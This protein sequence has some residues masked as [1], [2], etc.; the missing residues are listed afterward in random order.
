[1]AIKQ[2]RREV[3]S[4]KN[5]WWWVES[6]PR[7]LSWDATAKCFC[8]FTD[9]LL[10]KCS[11]RHFLIREL[12]F[13]LL[14]PSSLFLTHKIE[15]WIANLADNFNFD[16]DPSVSIDCE[17]S[18]LT[19]RTDRMIRWRDPKISE[20]SQ[21][22][23]FYYLKLRRRRRFWRISWETIDDREPREMAKVKICRMHFCQMQ[24]LKKIVDS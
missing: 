1:M 6:N 5:N 9:Q 14:Q 19:D 23:S 8:G 13:L 18:R 17:R 11:W 16:A 10:F 7:P 22:L 15:H 4:P 12:R 3:F 2:L 21:L 24:N 20:T